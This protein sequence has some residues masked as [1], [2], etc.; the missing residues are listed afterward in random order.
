[1]RHAKRK[2]ENAAAS[3]LVSLQSALLMTPVHHPSAAGARDVL[4]AA[5]R[6]ASRD[7]LVSC[8]TAQGQLLASVPRASRAQ[9]LAVRASVVRRQ[10]PGRMPAWA[11]ERWP[12]RRLISSPVST[13]PLVIRA[14]R[15]QASE[16]GSHAHIASPVACLTGGSI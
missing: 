16:A 8:A 11:T 4:R 3:G 10:M 1:M 15:R 2:V 12:G 7:Y 13:V 9:W 5:R 6:N 14:G